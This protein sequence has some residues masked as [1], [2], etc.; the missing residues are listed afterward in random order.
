MFIVDFILTDE[1]KSAVDV[2]K[3]KY[4]AATSKLDLDY[5]IFDKFGKE[6]LKHNKLSPDSFMQLALQVC[7]SQCDHVCGT[8]SMSNTHKRTL[9]CSIF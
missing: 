5:V 1:L 9:V 8:S 6:R 2:A 4:E 7:H 3:R